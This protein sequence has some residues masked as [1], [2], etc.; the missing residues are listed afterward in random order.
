LGYTIR[1]IHPNAGDPK[2]IEFVDTWLSYP[3]RYKCCDTFACMG[4]WLVTKDEIADPHNLAV[5]YR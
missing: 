2:A 4:P 3:G 1:R 5:S